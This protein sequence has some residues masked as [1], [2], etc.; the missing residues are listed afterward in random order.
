MYTKK[1]NRVQL[2]TVFRNMLIP[3]VA[4][5]GELIVG[6]NLHSHASS[7]VQGQTDSIWWTRAIFVAV[8]ILLT[9][10][11]V[12]YRDRYALMARAIA[13]WSANYM[14]KRLAEAGM[15][16]RLPLQ[17]I[18]QHPIGNIGDMFKEVVHGV[19]WEQ[20]LYLPFGVPRLQGF[21]RWPLPATA[22]V[23]SWYTGMGPILAG[24]A[25]GEGLMLWR[26]TA[27]RQER[28][29]SGAATTQDIL[30]YKPTI[31]VRGVV[32]QPPRHSSRRGGGG[33]AES[34]E[35]ESGGGGYVVGVRIWDSIRDGWQVV[36]AHVSHHYGTKT[37]L[38]S[39]GMDSVVF[40]VYVG[41]MLMP[42]EAGTGGG[43]MYSYAT[44]G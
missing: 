27:R 3:R 42:S 5:V 1:G 18:R 21:N 26:Q 12:V 25:S 10:T 32:T 28:G 7:L 4:L 22:E 15:M 13:G 17:L 8:D 24:T 40:V 23:A 38:Q 34:E 36:L 43:V 14:S 29:S 39:F 6:R 16:T 2:P 41:Y 44:P 30:K 20:R 19:P 33:G 31:V 37:L 9:D 35:A 11:E